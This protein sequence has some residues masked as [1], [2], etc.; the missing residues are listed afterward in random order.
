MMLDCLESKPSGARRRGEEQS[1]Q[2]RERGLTRRSFIR[3]GVAGTAVLPLLLEACGGTVAPSAS[4][5]VPAPTSNAG[6][7]ASTAGSTPASASAVGSAGAQIK[8]PLPSY[9]PPANGPKP[10]FR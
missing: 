1:M 5:G 8:G 10:D 4:L 9:I 6:S 2:D 7:P 3:M